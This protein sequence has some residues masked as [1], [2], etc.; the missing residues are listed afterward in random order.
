MKN[1]VHELGERQAKGLQD[2]E[3]KKKELNEQI[4]FTRCNLRQLKKKLEQDRDDLEEKQSILQKV[5]DQAQLVQR[6]GWL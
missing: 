3:K 1:A 4:D 2:F 6:L 5:R